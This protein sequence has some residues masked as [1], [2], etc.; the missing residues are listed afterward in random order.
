MKSHAK[1]KTS[2]LAVSMTTIVMVPYIMDHV[3]SHRIDRPAGDHHGSYGD[4]TSLIAGYPPHV[5][6]TADCSC[7][8]ACTP[9][10]GLYMDIVVV[11]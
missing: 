9:H 8:H 4:V 1:G 10:S 7:M 2:S 6:Y 3:E 5:F 11:D